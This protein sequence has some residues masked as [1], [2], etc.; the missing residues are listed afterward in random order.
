MKNF[1]LKMV[2]GFTLLELLVVVAIIGILVT[3]VI[4]YLGGAKNKGADAAVK[5][6]L[7]TI[8]SQSE[9]FFVNNNSFL[10]AGGS[11]FAMATCPVYNV[12]GTNML[13]R[14]PNISAAVAEATRQGGNGNSCYNSSV[15]WAVAVG[16]KTSGST[17]WCVD[18]GGNSKQVAS[19]PASAINGSTFLCN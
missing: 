2:R 17:S 16:L 3:V 14:D 6:N 11:T 19:A 4:A 13:S 18:Y 10:P 12:A 1:N 8:R 7:D 5:S 9:L 15:A